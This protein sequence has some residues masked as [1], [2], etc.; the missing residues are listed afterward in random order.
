MNLPLQEVVS[1]KNQNKPCKYIVSFS[2]GP[3]TLYLHV[4][5]FEI[6]NCVVLPSTHV[7]MFDLRHFEVQDCE[8]LFILSTVR[9]VGIVL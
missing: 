1:M 5:P 4:E 6:H 3:Q 7:T 8:K 9:R 2:R